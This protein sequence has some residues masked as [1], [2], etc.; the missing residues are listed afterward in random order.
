MGKGLP[1][2]H[3]RGVPLEKP[4]IKQTISISALAFTVDGA[5]GVGFGTVLIGDFPEGNILFLGAVAYMSVAG[6]GG[7]AG[8]VD[9]WEGDYGIGTIPTADGDLGDAG[10]DDIIPSTALAGAT[11]E[12][13]PRTR[14]V[15]T[16]SECGVIFDN[17][18]G[19]LEMNL[20]VL[21]DDDDIS[22]DGIAFTAT[23]ELHISY[24][25]LGDD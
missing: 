22:A 2:S 16:S 9:A 24:T 10:D 25:M 11:A 7:D 13:S 14:G 6:P 17:T 18:D 19:S 4:I 5:S 15:S 8:L 1:R 21:V 3:S 12:V 20:N 23:G